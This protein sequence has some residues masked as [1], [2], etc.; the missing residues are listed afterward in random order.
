M[1]PRCFFSGVFWRAFG[2][3]LPTPHPG[4]TVQP[5]NGILQVGNKLRRFRKT[6]A[7]KK[8]KDPRSPEAGGTLETSPR[9]I[10]PPRLTQF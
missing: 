1:N 8:L 7:S 6:I 4:P 2:F 3:Y 5:Q 9:V 10:L